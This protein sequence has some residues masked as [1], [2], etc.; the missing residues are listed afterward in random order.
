MKILRYITAICMFGIS[1]IVIQS[2]SKNDGYTATGGGGGRDSSMAQKINIQNMQFQPATVTT[3]LGTK[4]TWTNLDAAT[5]A[6]ISDDGT[7]FSSGNISTGGNFNFTV[8]AT[9]VYPYHCSLHP[10]EQGTIY[11]LT[12]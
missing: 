9:G 10:S 3:I 8:T 1:T 5:H 7:S 6:V 12:R 2:C 11:V 4:I